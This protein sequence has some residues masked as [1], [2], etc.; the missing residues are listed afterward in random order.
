MFLTSVHVEGNEKGDKNAPVKLLFS[1]IKS[2]ADKAVEQNSP[3]NESKTRLIIYLTV[4]YLCAPDPVII[5]KSA[6]NS[7][8]MKYSMATAV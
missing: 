6:T 7:A 1:N 8:L 4:E 5:P 2:K 3:E